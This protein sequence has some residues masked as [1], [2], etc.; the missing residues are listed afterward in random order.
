MKRALAVVLCYPLLAWAQAP[1]VIPVSNLTQAP[2]LDGKL[3]EWGADG[4]VKVPIK[5]ALDRAEREKLGMSLDDDKNQTGSITV[6]VKAGV[7]GGRFFLALK[8]PDEAADTVFK[9]WEWRNDKYHEGKQ[10]DDMLAVRFH[11]A[12]D[13]DRSML[14]TRI[15]RWM[16]GCG[17][18]HAQIRAGMP[19]I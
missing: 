14:T 17:L 13:F 1:Q 8:Y 19:K 2:K 16:S 6:Q 18:P 5:P 7:Q 9:L 12:G 3:G 11:M 10:R 4:W 15:T